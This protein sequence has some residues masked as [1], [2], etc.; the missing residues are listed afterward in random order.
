M[1][2]SI[3]DSK[4]IMCR[5]DLYILVN[6]SKYLKSRKVNI[7]NKE[8][9]MDNT[10]NLSRQLKIGSVLLKNRIIMPA[11]G[12]AL[13]N[14]SGEV[15]R[16]MI[17]Y[18]EERAMGGAGGI[19]VEIACV[20]SPVGKASLTQVCIDKPQY[21]AG[22]KELSEAIQAHGCKAF[23]Q[24]HHAGRQTSQLVTD[25]V[26]PVAPSPIACRFMKVEPRELESK[27]ISIIRNK[28]IMA[29]SM[30]KQAGFDGVEIHAAHGYLLS[31]FLSPYSNHRTDEYGGTTENRV[32]LV[33]EIISGIKRL[34][35]NLLVIVRFNVND[36]T[37]EGIDLTEGIEIARYLEK[38]GAD[39]LNVSCGIYESGH[40]SI[41]PGFFD[42][43][44][45]IEMVAQVKKAVNV[46]IIAGGVLRHPEKAEEILANRQADLVWIGRGMLADP[47][48]ALKAISGQTDKIRHCI[49]CNNCIDSINKGLHIRCA[50]NPRAGR[51]YK[52]NLTRCLKGIK[53][54]IVGGG[55]A[56]I[57]AA[58][59]LDAAGCNVTLI[60]KGSLLGGQLQ[61]ADKPPYK[62]KIG[63]MRDALI[64]QL[65]QTNV[66][67]KLNTPWKNEL[68][69]ELEFDILVLAVGSQ[70]TTPTISGLDTAEVQRLDDILSGKVVLKQQKVLIIGGGSSGCEAAEYLAPDNEVTI[71]EQSKKLAAGLENMNRLG[72]MARIKGLSIKT[73]RGYMVKNIKGNTIHL[74]KLDDETEEQ[75]I[76]DSI[77]FACGSSSNHLNIE[78]KH[79]F[80]KVYIIGDAKQPRGIMEAIYEGELIAEDLYSLVQRKFFHRRDP[81]DCG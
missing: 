52:L 36:F 46:P 34:M 35:P 12:T 40:T 58:L 70:P 53:A 19:I 28:F 2:F 24:L 20:D 65:E 39:V 49:S 4:D 79:R 56:G 25:G 61:I 22:L 32:R 54:L 11:M 15:T 16:Q 44:W 13:A 72:L 6:Y 37:M 69:E 23:I 63:W 30:A 59:G 57:Q 9:T 8:A 42:E 55:P 71:V 14:V 76:A 3:A 67:V 47:A 78:N 60:E 21:L 48:W 38:A 77:I 75:I 81:L 73:K 51:E 74:M 62:E 41:E 17:D 27:E 31:Q 10:N 18:Y 5:Y 33:A 80:K 45:R 29:A 43:A 1:L 26:Q 64:K 66:K 68:A 7:T 50:V